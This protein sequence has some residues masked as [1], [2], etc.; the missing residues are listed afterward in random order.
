MVYLADQTIT[1]LQSLL[2]GAALGVL[3]DFFRISRVAA[4]LSNGII[5]AEDMLFFLLCGVVT[6]GFMM[7]QVDG[8]IRFFILVGELLGFILY[9]FT[10]GRLVMNISKVIIRVIKAILRFIYRFIIRP[11]WWLVYHFVKIILMPFG[12]LKIILKKCIKALKYRLKT[13]V[14]LLYNQYKDFRIKNRGKPKVRESKKWRR[15][16]NKLKI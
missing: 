6:F 5:F 12:Y 7:Q 16:K 8:Q 9:Y 1:F 10:A 14:V 15:R 4:P 11:I 2:I 13:R 3:F